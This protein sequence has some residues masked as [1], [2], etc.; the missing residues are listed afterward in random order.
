MQQGKRKRFLF[1]MVD[2]LGDVGI[3]A[4]NNRTPLQHAVT[5]AMDALATAGRNGLMD[6][7]EVGLAC[8]SDT[9][10]LSILGYPP[11]T[12]YRGRGAFET[13]G[14]GLLMKPG[15]I[16][17][18]SNFATLDP[19]TNIVVSRRADRNFEDLGPPL[20]S[21][22]NHLEIPGFPEYQVDFKYATE[23]RDQI[24][25][26]DPLKDNLPL[27]V[28]ALSVAIHNKLTQHPI[29]ETRAKEGKDLANL[30]LLRGCGGLYDVEAFEKRHGLKAFMVAPTCIIKGLGMSL[31]IGATG[32]YHTD[33]LSKG[34]TGV[35]TLVTQDY[36]F[37]FV[38]VKAVDDAGHDRSISRKLE[39]LGKTDEMLSLIVGKLVE[40][41]AKGETEFSVCLTGD[42]STPVLYGDHSCEPVPFV[43]ARVRDVWRV[44][45]AKLAASPGGETQA[46]QEALARV[47][48][49]D[50][51][52]GIPHFSEV[53]AARGSLGRFPGSEVMPIIKSYL[54]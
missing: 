28:N 38:H 3:P 36:D 49:N 11:R 9:A 5:P 51:S 7:V 29:N 35:H 30:I 6:P 40:E 53:D 50:E 34:R 31:S 21:Y 25:G 42:H 44:L 20:C 32:D 24:S 2:G 37:G 23:H 18:K 45:Q 46:E 26:T 27:I 47:S 48:G 4:L 17:F 39:F 16:A 52:D 41:E 43:I 54:A 19:K 14:A 15:D 33:L 8:G 12:Y 1:V 13:M 10:H 22:L